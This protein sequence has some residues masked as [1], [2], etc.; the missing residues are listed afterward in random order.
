MLPLKL[1]ATLLQRFKGG[2]TAISLFRLACEL[3][4]LCGDHTLGVFH[5][6]LCV[7]NRVFRYAILAVALAVFFIQRANA[8]QNF[9]RFRLIAL[10]LLKKLLALRVV[11]GN[12]LLGELQV[13]TAVAEILLC[14][15]D[16]LT[17]ALGIVDP[18]LNVSLLFCLMQLQRLLG[19]L[20]LLFKGTDLRR[21][22]LEHVVD[23]GHVFLSGSELALG[24]G[25]AVA[26]FGN[27]RSVLKNAAALIRF[28]G[29]DLRDLTLTDDGIAVSANARIHEQL[30]NIAQTAGA[31]VDKI[32]T[33]ARAVIAA[34]HD[35]LIVG[36]IQAMI[37][38]G[39]VKGHRD[40]G[41]AHG[42]T[43]VGTAEDDIL[44]L[45]AAQTFGGN[46]TKH[47]THRIGNV[48]LAA[49]VG[50]DDNGSTTLKGQLGLIRE[51]FKALHFQ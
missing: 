10:R 7:C 14:F 30:I 34:R 38:V 22:L 49:A 5:L 12:S 39:V 28:T 44:H 25:F 21:D 37:A 27:A 20:R 24:F 18:K 36:A 9:G 45:G 17:Q 11:V 23:T 42:A 50:A 4:L 26:V 51:G 6:L 29:D 2:A 15:Y 16:L 41:K 48:G 43:A 40:L 3:C 13:I 33:L 19:A 32:F 47:P 31:T 46:L 35:H 1:G 8:L